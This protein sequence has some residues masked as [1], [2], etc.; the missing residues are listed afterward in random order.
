MAPMN[1]MREN[2]GISELSKWLLANAYAQSSY[3]DVGEEMI[4]NLTKEVKDYRELSGTF[5]SSTRDE[6]IIL[7]TLVKL[8]RKKDAFEMLQRIAEFM[9]LLDYYFLASPWG[10]IYP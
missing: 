9:Q 1:R 2:T 6:A 3:Q 5:G 7:E 4:T 8:G 10:R